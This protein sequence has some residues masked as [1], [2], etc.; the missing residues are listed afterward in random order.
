MPRSCYR[1]FCRSTWFA[2]AT[3]LMLLAPASVAPVRAE[4]SA[5]GAAPAD[6]A[7]PTPSV[8]QAPTANQTSPANQSQLDNPASQ[9]TITEKAIDKVKQV[10]KS[11]GD[12][13][14]R[15]PCLPPK[16]LSRSL[17][18]LPR[19]A[20]KLN[21]GEPI[22]IVAFGSSSTQGYGTTSPLYTYPNR[23]AEQLRRKF[24]KSEINVINR[25]VGGQEVPQMVERLGELC[26][27]RFCLSPIEVR[28]GRKGGW[29]GIYTFLLTGGWG[30]NWGKY[31]KN[32]PP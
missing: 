21:A 32:S 30:I 3:V 17:G 4:T 13:F 27:V 8:S 9:R 10:A 29:G 1:P 31:R 16:G 7:S 2:A 12:I 18:T 22:T 28:S 20:R 15:V 11:A 5:P 25:G 14:S 6:N 23:L 24:P 26:E 19:V